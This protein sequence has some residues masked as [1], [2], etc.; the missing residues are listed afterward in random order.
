MNIEQI[1][2]ELKN[3]KVKPIEDGVK[4]SVLVPLIEINNEFNLI[5]EVRSMSI[6]RQP[7]EISFPGGRIEDGESPLEASV[8]ETCEETDINKE[9][10][11]IISEL[12]YA[13]S[14]NGSF[15]YS[16]LGYVKNTEYS[17]I[18]FSKE[19]VSEL[20]YVPLSFFLEN[21]PEKYYINYYPETEDDFPLHMISEGAN[22]NWGS[23]RYP[24]YFYKYNNYIIWGLTAKITYSL[25]KKL[26]Q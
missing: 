8:R 18:G 7:G 3:T 5:F 16:F 6:K 13:S 17:S 15:V 24:V 10:I 9:N 23:F 25:I 4:F 26:K 22:Y 14:K 11:E 12:D 19:E 20:F 21:E 2:N 1:K